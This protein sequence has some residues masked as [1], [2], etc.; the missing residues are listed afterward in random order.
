MDFTNMN[1]ISFGDSFTFG[2]GTEGE[3]ISYQEYINLADSKNIDR[4]IASK[5]WII[6]SNQNAYTK[7]LERK[8]KFKT[9]INL[10]QMGSSNEHTI[11]YLRT[12][13]NK[14][15]N[16][17][18]FY[19]INL[20]E[21]LRHVNMV[22]RTPI[23]NHSQHRTSLWLEALRIDY[24]D[25]IKTNKNTY[26]NGFYKNLD[27]TFWQNYFSCFR[28]SE[29][30][31]YRHIQNYYTICEILKGKNYLIFDVMNNIDYQ[32]SKVNLPTVGSET[33]QFASVKDQYLIDN[34]FS[35][36]LEK[37]DFIGEYT[38]HIKNNNN[39]FDYYELN[40]KLGNK[41]KMYMNTN[42]FIYEKFGDSMYNPK[43][44]HWNK[45]GH[46]KIAGMLKTII[47]ERS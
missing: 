25:K 11:F 30:T 8:L 17:N 26:D 20:T 13:I 4:S 34:N 6:R 47:Q 16:K 44:S 5:D 15:H 12:F 7:V 36:I 41:K 27:K 40:K 24:L 3:G 10:G 28:T 38:E 45:T 46:A 23:I 42:A 14:N 19:L 21:P 1:L 18:N 22:S 31:T 32:L 9:S 29:E 2:Q 39:Y 35:P 33:Q 37:F 43:D